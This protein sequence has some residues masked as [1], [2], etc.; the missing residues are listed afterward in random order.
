MDTNSRAKVMMLPPL[1]C[2]NVGAHEL[3]AATYYVQLIFQLW[4]VDSEGGGG[5]GWYRHNTF[6]IIVGS[7]AVS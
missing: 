1:P 5:G 7:L 4:F 2:I 6:A 3:M